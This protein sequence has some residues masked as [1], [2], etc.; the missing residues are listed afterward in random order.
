MCLIIYKPA[1]VE[2]PKEIIRKAWDSNNHGA[3]FM[4]SKGENFHF[5]KGFF[6]LKALLSEL[7]KYKKDELAIHL[8]MAT[9]GA[10]TAMNCHPFIVSTK[11]ITRTEGKADFLLM[12]NGILSAYGDENNSDSWHFAREALAPLSP[13]GRD[14]LLAQ[15][16]GKFCY[17]AKGKFYTYG[18]EKH[19]ASGCFVSNKYFEFTFSRSNSNSFGIYSN[20]SRYGGYSLIEEGTKPTTETK[21]TTDKNMLLW[22][23]CAT[24]YD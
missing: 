24:E 12:H 5:Q 10:I 13:Q 17:G 9:H 8:R 18:M 23:E 11:K 7:A 19:A 16:S 20:R 2:I 14:R 15:I 21:E 22:P 1:A 6:K 4:V 3:G